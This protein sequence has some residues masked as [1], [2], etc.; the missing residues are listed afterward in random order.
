[1]NAFAFSHDCEQSDEWAGMDYY[2][3]VFEDK[4]RGLSVVIR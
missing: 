4:P 3:L 1:L 2:R